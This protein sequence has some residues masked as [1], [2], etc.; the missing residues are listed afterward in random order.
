M[1]QDAHVHLHVV[2]RYRSPRTFAGVDFPVL[3]SLDG[4]VY[5]PPPPIFE[6]LATTIRDDSRRT[7]TGSR[8]AVG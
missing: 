8:T 3:D 6:G 7:S 1:N 5:R 4:G 2:P